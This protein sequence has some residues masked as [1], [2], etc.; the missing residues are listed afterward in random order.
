LGEIRHALTKSADSLAVT[1]AKKVIRLCGDILS[2]KQGIPLGIGDILRR[3]MGRVA[4][5]TAVIGGLDAMSSTAKSAAI[6]ANELAGK[7]LEME[8]GSAAS[9]QDFDIVEK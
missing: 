6:E 8:L 1:A 7:I 4:S 9:L 2:G 5:L 3:Q